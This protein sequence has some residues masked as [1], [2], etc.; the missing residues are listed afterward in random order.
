MEVYQLILRNE[1][2]YPS[3]FPKQIKSIVNKFCT[4]NPQKRLGAT[5]QGFS[6]IQKHAWF[7]GFHWDAIINRNSKEIQIPIKPKVKSSMDVSNFD[8]DCIEKE[9]KAQKCSWSPEGF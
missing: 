4:L 2:S 3:K 1:I 8:Q 9:T 7:S 6:A 5:K